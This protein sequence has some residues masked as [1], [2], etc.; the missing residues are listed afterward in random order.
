MPCLWFS[1]VSPIAVSM[2][3]SSC[4]SCCNE[5]DVV[6]LTKQFKYL[7]DTT[8]MG[9]VHCGCVKVI[10]ENTVFSLSMASSICC[11]CSVFEPSDI[12][13]FI[14]GFCKGQYR[15]LKVLLYSQYKATHTFLYQRYCSPCY[16]LLG[17]KIT[18]FLHKDTINNTLFI[19]NNNCE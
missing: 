4:T 1:C 5:S 2:S 8:P 7:S 6:K 14:L 11:S 10:S 16:V 18:L 3:F 15:V 17:C 19:K 12:V 13:V 9:S